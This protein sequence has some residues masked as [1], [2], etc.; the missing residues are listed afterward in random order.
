[1]ASPAS[2]Y[3]VLGISMG[4]SCYEIKSAYR[5]LARTCHPDVVAMNQ[6][7]NSGNQF[8]KINSAYSTLSDP[9]KR[10][11]YDREIYGHRRSPKIVS[12]SGRYHQTV[13]K[14]GRKWET[15]QCW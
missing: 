10:A 2:Y 12:M 9:D 15:D 7:E 3:E 13:S 5:K 1:M 14:S 4:A 6:K 11:Q 8:M